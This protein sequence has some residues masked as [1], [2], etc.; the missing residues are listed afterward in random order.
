MNKLLERV[1][2]ITPFRKRFIYA[3]LKMIERG[4]ASYKTQTNNLKVNNRNLTLLLADS[5]S[6]IQQHLHRLGST[7]TCPDRS[8]EYTALAEKRE[9]INISAAL[10]NGP[11]DAA[12]TR[13]TACAPR[14][15]PPG[16]DSRCGC[17]RFLP[18]RVSCTRT[19]TYVH[20]QPVRRTQTHR[21]T[22]RPRKGA[23]SAGARGAVSRHGARARAE[24]P[25]GHAYAASGG[26][27]D[28]TARLPP[29]CRLPRRDRNMGS[30]Q[31]QRSIRACMPSS[32][33]P[34]GTHAAR[35]PPALSR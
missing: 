23:G 4:N 16:H 15:K 6:A 25:A 29:S 26:W 34:T 20:R 11:T 32:R 13:Q 14:A 7:S 35:V 30:S 3:P 18:C 22:D 12:C 21:A 1:F 19:G 2:K 27:Q 5:L 10:A 9:P 8:P 28:E 33:R 31:Q 17:C 24:L